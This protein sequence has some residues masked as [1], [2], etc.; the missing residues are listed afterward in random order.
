MFVKTKPLFIKTKP[1]LDK[2]KPMFAIFP[3]SVL[4]CHNVSQPSFG[5]LFEQ[6]LVV[7]IKIRRKKL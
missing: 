5:T 7:T 3:K 2:S 4:A 1:L 6:P